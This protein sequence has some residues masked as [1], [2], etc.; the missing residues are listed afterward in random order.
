MNFCELK[1]SNSDA[2]PKVVTINVSA[3]SIKPIMTWYGSHFA[4]DRYTVYVDG[5]KVRKD[6]N[7]DLIE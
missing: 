5:V 4:G 1:F 3:E 2:R 7:G 6:H